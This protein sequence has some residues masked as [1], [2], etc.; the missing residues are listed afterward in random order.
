VNSGGTK[1]DAAD[2]MFA[3]MK[4]N[5]DEIEVRIEETVELLNDGLFGFDWLYVVTNC[6]TRKARTWTAR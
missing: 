1:L 3:A 6:G 5:M 4:T 2:L